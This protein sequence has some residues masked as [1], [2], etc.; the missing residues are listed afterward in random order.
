MIKLTDNNDELPY[1]NL[2]YSSNCRRITYDNIGNLSFFSDAPCTPNSQDQWAIWNLATK[3][4]FQKQ[5]DGTDGYWCLNKVEGSRSR[6]FNEYDFHSKL[7]SYFIGVMM[8]IY[9]RHEKNKKV[10]ISKTL[11]LCLW[12]LALATMLGVIIY[13]QQ[14]QIAND[15]VGKSLCYSVTRPM[16]CLALSWI[17]YACSTG[18]GGIVNWFLSCPFMQLGGK[19]TYCIYIVHGM[20]I[21]HYAF[22][23]A[24]KLYFSDWIV[25]YENCGHFIVSMLIATVWTLAFESPMITIERLIF[26][27]PLNHHLINLKC[28]QLLL[29]RLSCIIK[30]SVF[31]MILIVLSLFFGRVTGQFENVA[32]NG[33]DFRDV[34]KE[35]RS[36]NATIDPGCARQLLELQDNEDVLV[37]KPVIIK[38]L[39]LDS[40]ETNHSDSC[41]GNKSKFFTLVADS[42]SKF[43]YTGLVEASRN[44]YG[45]YDECLGIKLNTEIEILGKHCTY[46]LIIPDPTYTNTT[47]MISNGWKL[48]YCVPQLCTSKDLQAITNLSLFNDLICTTNESSGF[49]F[50]TIL[51][52]F[53]FVLVVWLIIASTIYDL[54][55][56]TVNIYKAFSLR[57]NW[58]VLT[59][60]RPNEIL[61]FH[62]IKF[63]SMWWIIAGHNAVGFEVYPV[64]NN[65]KVTEWQQKMS[66][67][68]IMTGHLAVDSFFFISGFLLGY[69]YFKN[70]LS[71]KGVLD[72]I[73]A[74]PSMILHRYLRLTPAVLMI[75]LFSVYILKYTGDGPLFSYRVNGALN[76]PCKNHWW[77]VFLYIQNYYIFNL[78]EELCITPLWYLC[79]DTQLFLLAP[80]ILI[81]IT[82][83]YKNSFKQTMIALL[84]LNIVCVL[85]PIF[86]KLN[87]KNYDPN[88]S[89]YDTQ[90]RLS[91]YFIGVTMGLYMQHQKNRQFKLNKIL[92]SIIWIVVILC[93]LGVILVTQNINL[94]YGYLAKT[95]CYS[96]TRPIWSLGLCWITFAC[97]TGQGGF[98]NWVLSNGF[99][100]LGGKL[101]YCVYLVHGPIIEHWAL[102]DK[103]RRHFSDFD[104]FHDWCGHFV[105][106]MLVATF[107]T[108]AFELPMITIVK[109]VLRVGN[110]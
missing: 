27:N 84:G 39:T 89:E 101:S 50:G 90:S 4:S 106:S 12:S 36:G 1:D 43:P 34:W 57:A 48:S 88:F 46:G 41:A 8:G 80:L 93:M 78:G 109:F 75:Y 59:Q 98:I 28:F 33:I 56:P 31:T 20:A 76:E 69:L 103:V 16:W 62:G 65:N 35:F 15:Y 10:V 79:A 104:M 82:I 11:N 52:I 110:K 6:A 73:R 21:A 55:Q 91:D 29:S 14:V 99:M 71:K 38:I 54:L 97:A 96:L 64:V 23:Q 45:Q 61:C 17:T 95:L 86:T 5:E 42:W 25:F 3:G 9:M 107:W 37:K 2:S 51:T 85:V 32:R 47:E 81:P 26:D 72:Q 60:S 22:G 108:L 83:L 68:Y 18:H 58:K 19:L 100:Q 94:N 74:V 92:N 105:L 53:L 77:A 40:L 13:R 63:I 87:W 44:D 67:A 30:F 66:S 102:T 70:Q 7:I 49:D 24:N